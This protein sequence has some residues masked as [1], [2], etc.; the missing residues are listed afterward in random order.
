MLYLM[1]ACR[2]LL[3]VVFAAAVAGKVRGRA[4]FGEFVSSIVALGVL[5]RRASVAA[6]YALTAAEAAA[7]LLLAWPPTVPLGF[8]A[9]VGTLAVLTGGI[10]ATLRRG[11]RVPCRC[12][13]ASAAPLGR[14]HVARNLVL[15][16]LGGAGLAAWSAAGASAPHPAG[17]VLALVAA[18]VG[19][20]L[21]VRLDDLMELFTV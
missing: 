5:P 16:A 17:A 15:A 20:L 8:A 6:A 13:G 3:A 12:F 14:V 7:V 10:L 11:R 19:A 18:G 2:A 21:V 4:A 1:I 9:A